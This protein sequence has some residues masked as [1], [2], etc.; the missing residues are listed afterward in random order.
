MLLIKRSTVITL[1]VLAAV[2]V[3]A[4][5]AGAYILVTAAGEL[6][7]DELRFQAEKVLFSGVILTCIVIAAFITVLIKSRNI[8]RDLNK[9]VRQ[10]R[11]NPEATGPGLLKLGETGQKLNQL[12]QQIEEISIKRGL[13]ISALSKVNEFLSHNIAE[14]IVLIDVSGR[15][16]QASLGY[17]EKN[18]L[19]RTEAVDHQLPLL[20][21]GGVEL[22]S[23]I[24]RLEK[25]PLPIETEI[26]GITCRWVP[27]YNS[28]NEISYIAVIQS[29]DSP[30]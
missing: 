9:L 3:A 13:K 1:L 8:N 22:L 11:L 26:D 5:A 30:N 6:S 28:A 10:N 16:I 23:I 29:Q 14:S 17:L 25:K 19:N 27:L 21:V 18:G 15:V 20:S 12:Y 7:P 2:S 4:M 24:S